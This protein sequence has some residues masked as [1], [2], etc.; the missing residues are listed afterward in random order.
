MAAT[1][2]VL[3]LVALQLITRVSSFA[4]SIALARGL[5]ARFYGLANVQLQLISSSA[6]FL[7]KEGLRRACQRVY[8]GGAGSALAHGMNLA[9]LSVPIT[10]AVAVACAY[11][12]ITRGR[13]EE[14]A[15]LVTPAEYAVTIMAVC[16]AAVVE[17]IADPGWLYAQANDL[18][19]R[20]VLAEGSAL[21]LKA[22]ATAWLA[23]GLGMGARAFGY[24]QLVFACAY[25]ALLYAL[26]SR[27]CTLRLLMPR[28]AV[29]AHEKAADERAESAVV[30]EAGAALSHRAAS[31]A[32]RAV[33]STDGAV[34]GAALSHRAASSA[35]RAVS[36][37]DGAVPGALTWWPRWQRIVAAQYCWQSVQKYALTEGERVVLVSL[38]PLAQQGEYALVSNL[39]SLVARLLLQ[40]FEEVAF[41]HFSRAAAAGPLGMRPL[42]HLY[43]LLR[44]AS[45]FGGVLLAFS[46]AYSWLLL[47]LLYGTQWSDG[48]APRLLAI[49]SGYVCLMA[50]NGVAE[51]FVNATATRTQLNSLASAMV[52]LS[53]AY[54][55]AAVLGLRLAG[56]AGLVLANSLSML[57]RISYAYRFARRAAADARATDPSCKSSEAAAPKLLPHTSVLIALAASALI[58]SGAKA[59][60]G[61]PTSPLA[62][63]ACHVGIGVLCLALVI[64]IVLKGEPDL[65]AAVREARRKPAD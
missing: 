38:S 7:S 20:R 55:P 35:A 60:L 46:P 45:I 18:I 34:P 48:E 27:H 57:A 30:G 31:S 4:L 53:L 24:G 13:P 65:L 32:A 25:V 16:A 50:I 42:R 51:A 41:A 52:A 21:V 3:A 12:V 28:A 33:S 10:A 56:S 62:H 22:A 26:L 64:V 9:W 15:Q 47:R 19:G 11:Y 54:V 40:P 2:S 8:A 29:E 5:G 1:A 17:A 23:L 39:G 43:S 36:S 37:T 6:L 44:G 61:T 14:L 58:T 49:Y 63:H 59:W